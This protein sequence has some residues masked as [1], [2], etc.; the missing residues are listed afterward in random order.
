M[1]QRLTAVAYSG[2]HRMCAKRTGSD[3]SY[4]YGW[5]VLVEKARLRLDVLQKLKSGFHTVPC[6][7]IE[8]LHHAPSRVVFDAVE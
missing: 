7:C 8:I 1:V 3:E 5:G 6:D 4:L 2:T